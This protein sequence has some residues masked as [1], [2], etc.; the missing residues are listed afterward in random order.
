MVP[1]QSFEQVQMIKDEFVMRENGDRQSAA[2]SVSE[3]NTQTHVEP[4]SAANT[5]ASEQASS[6]AFAELQQQLKDKDGIIAGYKA[7]S[8][9]ASW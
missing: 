3:A 4:N 2:A 6:A 1:N 8:E 5:A 7:A 9:Q